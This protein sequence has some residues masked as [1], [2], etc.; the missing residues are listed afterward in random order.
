LQH[1]LTTRP[2][3]GPRRAIIIDPADDLETGAVNAL[4]K[5]LEEPPAG[6]FFLLVTHRLGQLLPTIRSR[7]RILRFAP[8]AD[9]TVDRILRVES[10]QAD[11]PAPPPLP[12]RKGRRAWR[13]ISWPRIWPRRMS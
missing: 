6:T 4:L 11:T 1:R 12:P 13:W 8:L 7:C 9:D 10:P 2:T 5:S 3:L